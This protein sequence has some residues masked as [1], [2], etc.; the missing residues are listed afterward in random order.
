M[1]R[2]RI[3]VKGTVQGVGFRPFVHRL[4]TGLGLAG[5]VQNTT[6]GVVIEIAGP[7]PRLE[8][9]ASRLR[10]DAPPLARITSV[11]TSDLPPRRSR[12]SAFSRVN[13]VSAPPRSFHPMW[14]SARTAPPRVARPRRPAF[15]LSLHELH[16]LRPALQ[17]SD[18][19]SLRPRA[20]D[21]GRVSRCASSAR[22]NTALPPTGVSTRSP[23]RVRSAGPELFLDGKPEPDALAQVARWLRE[24]QV[25]ALKGLGGYHLA[26]DA[27]NAA[28]VETL[29]QRKGRGEK[30]FAV[31]VRDL[32]EAN[33]IAEVSAQRGR[34]PHLPRK[35]RR[36]PALP[37]RRPGGGGGAA[38][39]DG[40]RDA[41]LHAP[42]P[43]LAHPF[44][45]RAGDDQ[46]QSGRGAHRAY[47]RR[48][49]RQA[50]PDCRSHPLSQSRDCRPLR[51]L[52]RAR[53]G[54][55]GHPR[56]TRAWVRATARSLWTSRLRRYWR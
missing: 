31:M 6:G 41:P 17:P 25:I 18:R 48:S 33:R 10:T 40:R 35:P 5:W 45:A 2:R 24:G 19:H 50:G 42:A 23:S 46:R 39:E 43:A 34:P 7:T 55:V 52:R 32:E 36:D 22:P 11:E 29:R 49:A 30:P 13:P 38:T 37:P 12:A 14:P 3:L 21:D 44:A 4:A 47:R 8:E 9:F 28:A 26:C 56:P 20:D 15:R 16:E 51:R 27:R 1:E 53:R 54:R